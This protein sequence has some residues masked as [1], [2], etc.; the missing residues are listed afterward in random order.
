[1]LTSL[2]VEENLL[3]GAYPR[4]DT[5]GAAELDAIYDRFSNL[6]QRRHM[7][8]AVLAGRR[9]ADVGDRPRDDGAAEAD[10]AGRA[11]SAC[12]HA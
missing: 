2:T 3:M 7:R 10:H 8:A 4:R 11:R 5:P 6:A 9:T 12:R 1:M